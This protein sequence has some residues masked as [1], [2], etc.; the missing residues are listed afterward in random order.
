MLPI[1]AI[2]VPENS[3][4]QVESQLALPLQKYSYPQQQDFT[5]LDLNKKLACCHALIAQRDQ[6][7]RSLNQI[8]IKQDQGSRKKASQL[9]TKNDKLSNKVS[10]LKKQLSKL[11]KIN[12]ENS[13]LI[14]QLNEKEKK[15]TKEKEASDARIGGLMQ[16]N[17]VL[18][19]QLATPKPSRKRKESSSSTES[20]PKSKQIKLLQ[21]ELQ[22]CKN[23]LASNTTKLQQ[24]QQNLTATKI[25][26]ANLRGENAVLRAQTPLRQTGNQIDFNPIL[27]SDDSSA[28]WAD[29]VYSNN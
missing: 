3:N 29:N 11:N 6:E 27:S 23:A 2:S 25:E 12:I 10:N 16:E 28:T 5:I 13:A 1:S 17:Q 7:I 18:S 26:N 24:S 15:Y 8:I 19:Q 22:Q 9:F 20:S 4:N 14:T 21:E